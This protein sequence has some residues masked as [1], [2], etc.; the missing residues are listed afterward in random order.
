MEPKLLK[1]ISKGASS[2]VYLSRLNANSKEIYATKVSKVDSIYAKKQFEKEIEILKELKDHKNIIKL[3]DHRLINNNYY[4]TLEYCNGNSLL[5][6]LYSYKKKYHKPFPEEVVQYIMREIVDGLKYIHKKGIIQRDLKLANI[7]VKFHSEEDRKNLNMLNC[8]IKISDFGISIK[9]KEAFSIKG[10][11]VYADPRILKK[12]AERNDLKD[13]DGY[14]KSADIWSLGALCYEM[15]TGKWLFNGRDA[16]TYCKNLE[17]GNYSIPS[18]LSKELASFLNGMLQYDEKKRFDIDKL[19]NHDFLNKDISN[20]TK[21]DLNLLGSKLQDGKLNINIKN[22]T[23]VWGILN[24]DKNLS[25]I[26][27]IIYLTPNDEEDQQIQINNYK[28]DKGSKFNKLLSNNN[29]T[30]NNIISPINNN[31]P[32]N[33]QYNNKNNNINNLEYKNNP[34]NNHYSGNHQ[35]IKA[36]NNNV[37]NIISPANNRNLKNKNIIA[38]ENFYNSTNIDNNLNRPMIDNNNKGNKYYDGH[39]INNHV[40]NQNLNNIKQ[41]NPYSMNSTHNTNSYLNYSYKSTYQQTDNNS[42]KVLPFYKQNNNE[43]VNIINHNKNNFYQSIKNN[44]NNQYNYPNNI[45]N[46]QIYHSKTTYNQYNYPDNNNSH[47][48]KNNITNSQYNFQSNINNSIN[49]N[50][51]LN[52]TKDGFSPIYNSIQLTNHS[53]HK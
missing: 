1:K 35:K 43:R 9:A 34:M 13:S 30:N 46:S 50:Y 3:I 53:Q 39:F 7:L 44:A 38:Y 19:A 31:Y 23:T 22:N 17:Q 18:N 51:N 15:V 11:A 47:I 33:N 10:T 2:T 26:N 5:T 29:N 41:T 36:V 42:N 24:D 6:C 16:P 40:N 12:M 8:R 21:M 28:L 20:F 4:I 25:I 37:N 48:S 27:R 49:S 32:Q 52:N 45:S 14:D